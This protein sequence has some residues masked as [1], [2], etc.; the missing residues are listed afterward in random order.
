LAFAESQPPNETQV[1]QPYKYNGKELDQMHGLNQYDYAARYYDPA[2][3]RF[4]TTDPLAEKYYSIS[5]YAYCA[6]NPV[7]YVDPT[8]EGPLETV[9]F[10]I[11]H[12]LIASEIGSVSRTSS[13]ISSTVA[14]FTANMGLM[15]NS[16][17]EG[18]EVNAAR[19]AT[20]QAKITSTFGQDIAQQVGNAHEDNPDVNL[21]IRT[22]TGKDALKQADQTIDLLNNQ[23]GQDIGK[24]SMGATT[25]EIAN[26]VL[27]VFNKDGLFTA[28]QNKDGSI[29]ISRTKISDE[30]LQRAKDKLNNLGSN[31]M[32]AKKQKTQEEEAKRRFE[33]NQKKFGSFK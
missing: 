25:K 19:H 6:N 21:S 20:W 17:G 26:K 14:R 12:P 28:T 15:E 32:N 5:P 13:N 1:K 29:T 11:R 33:E 10:A 2:I 18:S 4:T 16:A 27:D 30:Q 23:I 8:G 3:A 7:R 31:G 9:K 22:F 24:N